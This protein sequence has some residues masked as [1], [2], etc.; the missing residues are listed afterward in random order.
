MQD[1]LLDLDLQEEA[2]ETQQT[3]PGSVHATSQQVGPG[4]GR[5]ALHH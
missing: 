4:A 2:A 5:A 3:D 1:D